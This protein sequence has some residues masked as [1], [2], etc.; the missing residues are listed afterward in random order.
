M[1]NFQDFF[2]QA[3]IVAPR[4]DARPFINEKDET[5]PFCLVNKGCL[6]RILDESWQEDE[7][8]ARI[9]PNRYPA[10]SKEETKG[11][12]DVIIDTAHHTLH[13]KDF[14]VAHWEE[15]LMMIQKR[16]NVLMQEPEIKLIQVF[17]NYGT[18][19]GASISHSHWQIIALQEI[20]NSMKSK[21]IAY[22][23]MG[24]CYLCQ[25]LHN[26]EGFL[27]GEDSFWEIWV[28]PAPEYPYEVWCIPK[29]HYQHYGELSIRETKKLGQFMKYLLEVYH[30]INPN[31]AFNICMM[32]GDVRRQYPYHFYVKLVMRV[33][34]IAG[35]EIATGCH[36]LSIAPETYANK[37]KK[38]LKGMY[39]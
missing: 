6:E 4:R 9:V 30:Q 23:H 18:S 8:L 16:W 14:T 10:T 19:A 33:G 21:Y 35:F 31:Y 32:S 37:M 17:K 29:N 28:P 12:H 7:L 3:S 24:E 39:K 5:C 34:H 36:I 20:P 25:E 22:N 27:I 11:K 1:K 13:P 2:D 26:E 38:M 15:I